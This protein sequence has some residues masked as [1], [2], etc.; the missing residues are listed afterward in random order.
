[1]EN[2]KAWFALSLA[3]VAGF[4]DA[5]GFLKLNEI[6]FSAVSGNTIGL[7]A[8][9]ARGDWTEV[10]RRSC[11]IIFFIVGFFFGAILERIAS[12]LRVHR[13]FSIALMF[14]IVLLLCF[15][16]IGLS[17]LPFQGISSKEPVMFYVMIALIS[18]AMG[19]QNASLRR[20]RSE[21]VNTP[22]ITGMLVQAMDNTVNVLFNAYDRLHNRPTMFPPDS[23]SKA[24]FHGALWLCFA[25]GAICGGFGE[26]IWK[27]PA[28]IAP[29]GALVVI[30]ICDLIRPIYNDN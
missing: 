13:R 9:L 26:V 29:L 28:L 10:A 30:I 21:S 25:I 11:P 22:F 3:W 16:L 24:V 8:S 27:F 7:N 18:G 5:F 23:L 4:V 1:M 17:G 14:E 6:F 19:I 20:V 12:R 2:E 15:L